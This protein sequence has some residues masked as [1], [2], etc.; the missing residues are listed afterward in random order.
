MFQN[1]L[2]PRPFKIPS[3]LP[4]L[5]KPNETITMIADDSTINIIILIEV[6][7]S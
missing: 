1:T 5:F 6:F 2:T 3:Q 4:F 7:P